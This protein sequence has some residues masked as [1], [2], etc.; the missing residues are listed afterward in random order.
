MLANDRLSTLFS[1][2]CLVNA[3]LRWFA[4]KQASKPLSNVGKSM[5]ATEKRHTLTKAKKIK[6]KTS[7][8]Q[9]I[10]KI[11]R[12]NQPSDSQLYHTGKRLATAIIFRQTQK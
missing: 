1:K 12:N 4:E 11:Q 10:Q 6:K 7:K 3:A 9:K 8:K 2:N 5:H